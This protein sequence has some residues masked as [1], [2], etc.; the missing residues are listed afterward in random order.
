M[1]PENP[2][3]LAITYIERINRRDFP[4]LADMMSPDHRMV[5]ATGEINA[6]RGES[7]EIIAEYTRK[8]P[9]FQIHIS[10][11]YL[12]GDSAVIIGRTTGSCADTPRGEEIR[13]RLI[14]LIR[15][16]GGCVVEFRYAMDDTLERR[17][18]LGMDEMKKITN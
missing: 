16:E 6:G 1:N 10:D 13:R 15:A 18:E 11:I 17:S 5:S 8:W 7:T 9:D 14:Y 4:G 2:V 12:K 3:D